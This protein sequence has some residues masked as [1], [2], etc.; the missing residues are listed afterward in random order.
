[1]AAKGPAADRVYG[2]TDREV[3]EW[4]DNLQGLDKRFIDSNGALSE[5]Q[6][7]WLGA[8]L[9]KADA[10]GDIVIVFGHLAVHPSSANSDCLLWNYRDVMDLF[11][12]HRSVALYLCGHTHRCGYATDAGGTHYMALAGIIE[13]E[14]QSVAFSTV[15]VFPDR[16]EVVGSGREES[17]ILRLCSAA[18]V[19]GEED[20]AVAASTPTAAP[21]AVRVAV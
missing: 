16:V 17:R 5:A 1:M 3:Q 4:P 13:T 8:E 11:E 6:L 20:G 19:E 21:L 15:T 2:T 10:A 7:H 9:T 12:A 18:A 14:P